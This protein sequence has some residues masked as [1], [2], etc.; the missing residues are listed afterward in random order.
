L[1]DGQVAKWW[2]P[3]AVVVVEEL[4]H[5]ATGKLNKLALRKQY[6]DYLLQREAADA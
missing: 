4:P 6:G 3:D 2:R 1:Y 5:T